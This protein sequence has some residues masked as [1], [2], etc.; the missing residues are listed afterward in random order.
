MRRLQYI[1]YVAVVSLLYSS[2]AITR[3]IPN[4]A[5]L[6]EKATIVSDHQVPK[7]ER[8]SSSEFEKY[9]RQAPNKRL[10]GVNFYLWLYNLANPKKD[11]RWNNFKR[12]I[13]EEPVLL[14]VLQTE[15]TV[16]NFKIYMNSKGYY[17]S[18]AKFSIDTTSRNK[19]AFV[20]YE[21]KQGVPYHINSISYK[22]RDESLKNEV[23]SDTLSCLI[24]KGDIF[25]VNR[26]EK[27][28]ARIASHL[29]NIG[30]YNFSVNN[31]EYIADTLQ[32]DRLVGVEIVIKKH[33][34]GYDDRGKIILNDNSKYIIGKV[35]VFT[36]YDVA[37][38]RQDTLLKVRLDTIEYRGLNLIYEDKINIRPSVISRA[39]PMRANTLYSVKL[40]EKTYSEL[41]SLGYFKQAKISFDVMPTP[42][43]ERSF[44]TYKTADGG[45]EIDS[46]ARDDVRYLECNILC[47]PAL[48]QS[49]KVE[50]EGSTTS[51]F[52]GL[53]STVGYQNRNIFKGAESFG[54]DVTAGFEYMKAVEVKKSKAEEFGVA[55]RL[56]IPR[57]MLPFSMSNRGLINQPK[58]EIELSVNFQDRPF[59]NRTLSSVSLSYQ[60]NSR[61]YSSFSFSPI[62]INVVD[63]GY[64]D[65]DFEKDLAE[66]IYLLNSY[67]TQF[68]AGLSFGYLYNNQRKNF[69]RSATTIRLNVETAGN[70]VNGL[71][72]LFAGPLD[73]DGVD[74]DNY[75]TIFGI[76]YAQYFRSDLSLSR[77]IMVGDRVVF[78]GRLYG[79][80]AV[81][82]GNSSSIPI[83]RMFYA[84]G[85]NGMR[86]WAPRTLGPGSELYPKVRATDSPS[87]SS[88]YVYHAQ[89]GDM[90]LEA[91]VE[92]RFPIWDMIQGA[93][94]FDVGNV[95]FLK[96]SNSAGESNAGVFYFDN[97][98]KQLGFNTGIGVSLDIKFA[99]L[100]LDWGLQLHNP[101]KVVGE[102][103][104]KN[105]EWKNT[106]LNFGVGY[107]F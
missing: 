17:S 39:T 78:A 63:M 36:N 4:D 43:A 90:K 60:W 72:P 66:N 55:T 1:M 47:T 12:R 30:Y 69:G 40:V 13:G 87:A 62:N 10:F 96:S 44:L 46:I 32:H 101:N 34:E 3:H 25:D 19:K 38:S 31:I 42:D 93:V 92:M 15:Q 75:Y 67:S 95:W 73:N 61:R 83:D 77:N 105:F 22:F 91:N 82:Y 52:Y 100:R 33:I 106:A 57:F 49:F 94:F 79:G 11:N 89:V 53:K 74:Y 102:R 45:Q 65:S 26:L 99:V 24:H 54:I 107:P 50:L 27:E 48:R 70:L 71:A 7:D 97:F 29:N 51:S 37:K 68:I 58:T 85:S 35:N 59:Y 8:I 81:A 6:L 23:L 88:N 28:R 5:Y 14:N 20:T 84:G 56:V 76:R 41:M 103:W 21:I 18:S 104:I 86:G 98:Y 80:I 64:L 2:C 9:A 16:D